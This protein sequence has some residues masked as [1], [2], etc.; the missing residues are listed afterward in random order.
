[1]EGIEVNA[2]GGRQSRVTSRLDLIPPRA[3]L[4]VGGVMRV[5]AERYERDNWRR[6]DVD[7]HINH[8]L[9]HIYKHLV[10][11]DGE[12]HLQHAAT[13]LLMALEIELTGVLDG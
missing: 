1:M 6:I 5:G 7:D 11:D 8:A 3:L 4:A 12:P 9:V 13:R 2:R 10:G